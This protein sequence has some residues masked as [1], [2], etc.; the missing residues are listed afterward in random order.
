MDAGKALGDD[1]LDAEVEGRERRVLARRALPVVR[2]AHDHA[3]AER[4][5]ACGKFGVADLKA[6]LGDF[7]NV[8]AQRQDL[9]TCG[10]DMIGGDIVVHLQRDFAGNLVF[11]RVRLGEG[12]DVRS[13]QNLHLVGVRLGGGQLDHVVVDEK[14]LGHF[15]LRHVAERCRIAEIAVHGGEG[16]DLGGNQIDLGVLGAASAEEVAVEGAQRDTGGVRRLSHTDAGTARR[17]QHA[18]ARRDHVGES[19]VLGKH[20]QDLL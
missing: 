16:S 6:V 7:R 11:Q 13:A 10:H 14:F 17:F 5:G 4:P 12:L 8:G 15:D 9:C 18:R 20:V 3:L 19:A 2:A 1:R